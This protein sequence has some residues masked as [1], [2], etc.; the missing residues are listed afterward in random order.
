ME[1]MPDDQHAFDF[2]FGRW[3]VHNRKLRDVTDPACDEWIEFDAVTEAY[4]VLGG[5]G[6]VDLLSAAAS[7]YMPAF[8]GFTFRLFDPTQQRWRIWWSSTR[9]PG[10][11]DPPVV[12][13]FDGST[14]RFE[15]DDTIANRPVRVR[16][17]WLVDQPTRPR[18]E[19]SFSYDDGDSWSRNW[20]MALTRR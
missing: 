17:E 9:N 12:G 16:F 11:V 3:Y 10:V 20:T 4:P 13:G 18:W 8:E 5:L 7:A 2:I 1:H 14:G 15:C 6:H 19:Q